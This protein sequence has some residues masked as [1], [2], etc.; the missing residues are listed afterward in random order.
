MKAFVTY[1]KKNLRP[2]NWQAAP[3]GGLSCPMV[4]AG[5]LATYI[6]LL[7]INRA[8]VGGIA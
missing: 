8:A 4:N 3:L 1:L 6:N 7:R 5:I 2:C